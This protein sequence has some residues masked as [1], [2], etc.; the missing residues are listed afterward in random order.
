MRTS[1]DWPDRV[2]VDISQYDKMHELSS[3]SSD[4]RRGIPFKSLKEV[5]MA[6][7]ML[8]Y[9]SGLKEDL[10]SRKEIILTK[11]LDS[12]IDLPLLVCLAI[13]DEG[14]ADVIGDK[15]KVIEIFQSYIKGGFEA[16]YET[17][18]DG[19]DPIQNYAYYLIEN[20]VKED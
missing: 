13:A 3:K 7:A 15:K 14:N 9:N 11:Y 5:L 2:Y 12:Q 10:A 8:G 1:D 19:S 4:E 17:I 6:A 18:I 16:L 20:Y